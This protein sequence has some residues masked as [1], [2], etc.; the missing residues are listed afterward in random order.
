MSQDDDIWAMN[1]LRAMDTKKDVGLGTYR[2]ADPQGVVHRA[3]WTQLQPWKAL[4]GAKVID[5]MQEDDVGPITC[6]RCLGEGA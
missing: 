6:I 3:V 2:Y 4:C 1:R 5:K